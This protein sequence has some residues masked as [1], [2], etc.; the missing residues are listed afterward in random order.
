MDEQIKDLENLALNIRSSW[1]HCTDVLW[2]ALDPELW[3]ITQNPWA[4]LQT[5]SQ[6]KLR[7]LL[8]EPKFRDLLSLLVQEQKSALSAPGWFQKTHGSSGLKSVAYFSME[9]MLSEAL[10]IY[11]GGLG[12]VAGDQLKAASDL[13]VPV[14][15]IGLLYAQGYFRQWIDI[16]GEQRELYPYNDPGQLPI[17]PLRLPSGEWLR[18][19]VD[20]PGYCLWLRTWEVRVGRR[21]LYLLDSNDIGNEPSHRGITSE[22]YGGDKHLRL[23]QEL[24]LGIGGWRLL[25]ALG[26]VPDVCHMNEGHAAFV[27]LERA[28]SFMRKTGQPFASALMATRA[29]NLFTTHTAVPAG[30]DRFSPDL[31]AQ[32][33]TRYA[34]EKLGISFEELLA[35]GQ[36]NPG[37]DFNMAY[38]A[39]RGADMSMA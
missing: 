9:F 33:L 39:I 29:G 28:L 37:D 1:I 18:I 14:I 20:L 24:V 26:Q 4:V 11:S 27:V 6:D 30:F 34:E 13:D 31:I 7:G 38:L 10:P 2:R 17:K 21:M 15:G 8:K 25:E 16:D 35:L 3:E 32:Y 5:V 19:R 23:K 22:L 36:I 12:N